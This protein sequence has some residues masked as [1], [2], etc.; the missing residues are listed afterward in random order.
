MSTC[1]AL[2]IEHT[3]LRPN[4][5]ASALAALVDEAAA[6]RTRAVCVLPHAVDA[7][8]AHPALGERILVSVAAFPYG[9]SARAAKVA[10]IHALFE[11]GVA[12]VDVVLDWGAWLR[13]DASSGPDEIEALATSLGDL[14]QRVKVICETGM[15]TQAHLDPLCQALNDTRA[16]CAKTSTGCVPIGA[17]VESVRYLRERLCPD[18]LIK[19]AGGIGERAFAEQLIEAGADFIGTSR[20]ATLIEASS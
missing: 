14:W 8:L 7:C 3:L 13:G 6:L 10:E 19:A 4:A 18:I 17:S 9:A 15:L 16:F 11:A 2:R 20:S 1:F 5:S 12:E